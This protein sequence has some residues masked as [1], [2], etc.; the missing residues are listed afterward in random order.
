MYELTSADHW[1]ILLFLPQ[2]S[3]YGNQGKWKRVRSISLS[4]ELCP[5]KDVTSLSF[6]SDNKY[7]VTVGKEPDWT[8]LYWRWA[9]GKVGARPE[10]KQNKSEKA[11]QRNSEKQN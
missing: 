3:V 10:R 1:T 8:L 9:S 2:I 4:A 5:S 7:L 11:T 6:S